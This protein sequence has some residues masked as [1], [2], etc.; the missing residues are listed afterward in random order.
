MPKN[1][2]DVQNAH[3]AK[4]GVHG[5]WRLTTRGSLPAPRAV[6]QGRVLLEVNH[7]PPFFKD[8]PPLKEGDIGAARGRCHMRPYHCGSC[9][10][11]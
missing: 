4:G 11:E 8:N 10:V 9:G 2:V 5:G 7:K 6:L 3:T 1:L